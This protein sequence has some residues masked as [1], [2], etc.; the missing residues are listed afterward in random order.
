MVIKEPNW[1]S[2]VARTNSNPILTPQECK[3][4]IEVGRSQPMHDGQIIQGPDVK[5]DKPNI[6]KDVRVSHISWVPFNEKTF[7]MFQKIESVMLQINSNHFGFE[8]MQLTEE[9]QYTEY[10]TGGHYNWHIDLST[11][12]QDAPPVRKISMTLILSEDNEFEGGDLQLLENKKGEKI[13]QGHAIFF[14]SFIR[15]KVAPVTKGIRKSL[16]MWFGGTPF[17]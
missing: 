2:F 4:M 10:P 15:H 11:S 14:A 3:T 6:D 7:P 8:N 9:A 12:C 17:R 5:H 16:V 13:L 1:K